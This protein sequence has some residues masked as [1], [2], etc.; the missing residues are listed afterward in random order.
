MCDL[1]PLEYFFNEFSY[2]MGFNLFS[3]I[4]IWL[5]HRIRCKVSCVLLM[6]SISM[7]EYSLR[8][9]FHGD[10][11]LCKTAH[12]KIRD[13]YSYYHSIIDNGMI[14]S[15]GIIISNG[16]IISR[17]YVRIIKYANI[18]ENHTITHNGMILFEDN[19]IT[20]NGMI[21]WKSYHFAQL[22]NFLHVCTFVRMCNSSPTIVW[23]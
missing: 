16:M 5:L 17:R 2:W 11:C 14:I 7:V 6:Q 23:L 12:I 3:H 9:V 21:I 4:M 18:F 20:Y 15:N 1:T 19:T 10:V 13:T 8:G 22:H